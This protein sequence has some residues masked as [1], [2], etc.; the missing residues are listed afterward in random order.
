MRLTPQERDLIERGQ[1]NS[2]YQDTVK[3]V[4]RYLAEQVEGLLQCNTEDLQKRQG[5]CRGLVDLLKIMKGE[6]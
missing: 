3:M 4:E 1:G 6:K 2:I 5:A